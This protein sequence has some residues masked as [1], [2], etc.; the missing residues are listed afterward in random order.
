MAGR[1][2]GAPLTEQEIVMA[3]GGNRA[4]MDSDKIKSFQRDIFL[5]SAKGHLIREDFQKSIADFDRAINLDDGFAL[6]YFMRARAKGD[7]GHY[8]DAIV[9]LARAEERV[10]DDA[11]LK[12]GIAV[13]R[14]AYQAHMDK[15]QH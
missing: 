1:A 14:K 10:G 12:R 7:A 15:G 6:S 13:R 8:A 2:L 3:F 11:P 5:V 9:D 4:A